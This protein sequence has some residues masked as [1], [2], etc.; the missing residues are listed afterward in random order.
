MDPIIPHVAENFSNLKLGE[1]SKG[2]PSPTAAQKVLSSPE[3]TSLILSHIPSPKFLILTASR[4]CRAW[5]AVISSSSS[6]LQIALWLRSAPSP[7]SL[8]QK[9]LIFNDIL[10]P[11]LPGYFKDAKPKWEWKGNPL[12]SDL[13]WVK[14]PSAWNTTSAKWRDMILVQPLCTKLKVGKMIISSGVSSKSTVVECPEGLRL[15]LLYELIADWVEVTTDRGYREVMAREDQGWLDFLDES[16]L[17]SFWTKRTFGVFDH[18]TE[19]AFAV[20]VTMERDLSDFAQ[21]GST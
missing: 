20:T 17:D 7:S 5:N 12:L 10:W 15:G 21:S 11:L 6:E 8:F 19:E 1:S 16:E 2:S 14:N 3:L 4:V 13:P 9:P 18:E